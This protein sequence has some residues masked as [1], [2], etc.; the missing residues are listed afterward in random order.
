MASGAASERFG[1]MPCR[2]APRRSAGL[3]T[4]LLL[5]VAHARWDTYTGGRTLGGSARGVELNAGKGGGPLVAYD[6][7]KSTADNHEVRG[8]VLGL[9][10]S[11]ALSLSPALALTLSPE[12]GP[13]PWLG[14][15]PDP[16]PEPRC[17]ARRSA[18]SS[19]RRA[20][21]ST[22]A[23]TCATR[24]AGRT[25]RTPSSGRCC[26]SRRRRA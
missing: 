1:N 20:S 23:G 10:P 11:P 21:G 15:E 18:P 5:R 26:A 8:A 17:A 12:P 13:E 16:G 9:N 25:S 6:W 2:S 14:P 4:L 3:A 7:S 24:S 19:R 22:T